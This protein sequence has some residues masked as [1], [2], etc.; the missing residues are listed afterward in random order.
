MS[1]IGG[2]SPTAFAMMLVIGVTSAACAKSPAPV[3]ASVYPQMEKLASA[4]VNELR[5]DYE[6]DVHLFN[7]QMVKIYEDHKESL[8][9][10]APNGAYLQGKSFI[11][12]L[13]QPLTRDGLYRIQVMALPLDNGESLSNEY[14]FTIG[15]PA[16]SAE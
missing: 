12:P 2:V 15:E 13:Q 6:E 5:F 9:L 3:L 8:T 4:P 14:E 1:C 7:V 16:P 11:F 10:F